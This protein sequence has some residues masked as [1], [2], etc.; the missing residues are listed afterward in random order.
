MNKGSRAIIWAM[1]PDVG[2]AVLLSFFKNINEKIN[3]YEKVFKTGFPHG[4][5]KIIK[6]E[7]IKIIVSN[8]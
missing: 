4:V 7:I 5:I 3:V 2:E 8:H 1:K 6:A